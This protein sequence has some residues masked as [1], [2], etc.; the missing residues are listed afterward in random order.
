M[1]TARSINDQRPH[2]VVEKI[3]DN[4]AVG[5]IA[6]LGLAFKPNVDDLRESPAVEIAELVA[7]HDDAE[8]LICEPFIHELPEELADYPNVR[9]ATL[10]EASQAPTVVALVAH[11]QFKTVD[12]VGSNVRL[13]F[14]GVFR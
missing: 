4:A 3:L 9:L 5:P 13:D 2:E 1:K 14:V 12:K 10:E 6:I 7:Q 8:I 11:D